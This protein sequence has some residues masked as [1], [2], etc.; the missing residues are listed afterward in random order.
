MIHNQSITDY[1]IQNIK[2][3]TSSNINTIKIITALVQIVSNLDSIIIT[4]TT[5]QIL[6]QFYI[7][8]NHEAKV[9]LPIVKMNQTIL[10]EKTSSSK[11]MIR[12]QFI[13]NGKCN[14]IYIVR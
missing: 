10:F 13:K 11:I 2:R 3:N 14:T 8:E 6:Y 4:N 7:I 5:N 9:L 1:Q 12:Y